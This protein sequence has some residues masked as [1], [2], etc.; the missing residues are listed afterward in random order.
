[1]LT[2]EGCRT[3]QQRALSLLEQHRCDL[4][5]TTDYRTVYYFSGVLGPAESPAIFALW[6]D[7][8]SLLIT[9]AKSDAPAATE[10]IPLETYSILR[11]ITRPTHDAAAL[12]KGALAKKAGAPPSRC[13]VQAE[14]VPACLQEMLAGLFP[15]LVFYDATDLVLALRKKKE[16]D[17]IAEIRRSLHYCAVAYRTAKETIAPWLTEIDVYNAMNAA[18]MREAGTVVPFPGDFACG[19]RGINGGGPPTRREIQL[20]DLYPLDLFPAPALYFGDTC[21]TF[22]VGEPTDV[23]YR[24]WELVIQALHMAEAMIKPGIRARDVYQVVKGFL[25]SHELTEKSFWHHAGHGI[26][27]HGH[28]APRI[29]PGSGDVF[30]SGDVITLEPGVYTAALQG[31]LRLEDNYVVRDHGLENLFDFPMEL[32]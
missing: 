27:H 22:S 13:A 8:T 30:E 3:R 31:G 28:E 29:I 1:M 24:A 19:A 6:Q 26:G 12:F 20:H 15:H 18:I 2:L 10:V 4:F 16:K 25:D 23:Q 5:V 11:N 32:R 21:R 7:A 9:S 17:E 14:S